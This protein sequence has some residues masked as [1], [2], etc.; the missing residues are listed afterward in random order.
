MDVAWNM[1]H[2]LYF[3]FYFLHFFRIL[4]PEISPTFPLLD[5][6]AMV[7]SEYHIIIILHHE[8]RPGRPVSVSAVISSSSLLRGL[9]GRRLPFGWQ[10]RSC[11]GSLLSSVLWTCWNH[12]CL[13]VHDLSSK[14][15][16]WSSSNISSVLLW[17][18]RVYRAVSR[19]YFI[20]AVRSLFL[21]HCLIVQISLPY[22]RV[23]RANVLY[24]FNLVLLCTEFYFSV[25]FKSPRIC[26]NFVILECMSFYSWYE[27]LQP[28][29]VKVFT[30]CH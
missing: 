4:E 7:V 19:K 2:L 12:L 26:K 6:I 1:E 25:L 14:G 13:H 27:M 18:T 22:K 9:P 28:R 11:F 5:L 17:L 8:F 15:V 24:N 10:F 21:S 20:S 29:Y 23:G 30:E 16:T 3:S